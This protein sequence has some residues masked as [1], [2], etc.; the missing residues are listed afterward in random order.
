MQLNTQEVLSLYQEKGVD[1]QALIGSTLMSVE[2]T[3]SDYTFNFAHKDYSLA[4]IKKRVKYFQLNIKMNELDLVF[5]TFKI[6]GELFTIEKIDTETQQVEIQNYHSKQ[7]SVISVDAVRHHQYQEI[8]YQIKKF[9]SAYNEGSLTTK[10]ILSEINFLFS[11]IKKIYSFSTDLNFST[12]QLLVRTIVKIISESKIHIIEDQ[13][14]S[15][16][17][18]ILEHN[19]ITINECKTYLEDFISY[20]IP[21][22]NA[23][24]DRL[25]HLARKTNYKLETLKFSNQLI[26]LLEDYQKSTFPHPNLWFDLSDLTLLTR[27][28]LHTLKSNFATIPQ[29][30]SLV[31][32]VSTQI[33]SI[34]KVASIETD[35]LF[36]LIYNQINELKELAKPKT[37]FQALEK[38]ELI[39][40]NLQQKN[41]HHINNS[42]IVSI[43]ET[44]T[45]ADL[46][47]QIP[48]LQQGETYKLDA[49]DEYQDN[50]ELYKLLA[51]KRI[52][53]LQTLDIPNKETFF[54]LAYKN[55]KEFYIQIHRILRQKQLSAFMHNSDKLEKQSL[56]DKIMAKLKLEDLTKS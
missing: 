49:A 27:H 45:I 40:L 12:T 48:E 22:L 18:S 32:F 47:I 13:I 8:I 51:A 50:F 33:E 26:E 14:H 29:I 9:E 56:I 53:W 37:C 43:Y 3:D 52:E 23:I 11:S 39:L 55:P 6:N 17:Q 25:S 2:R 46:G 41:I 31:D 4:E 54:E 28:K 19:L 21:V 1:L 34:L 7:K 20:D 5:P 36:S 38:L 24:S 30:V 15:W 10:E 44:Q 35:L 16:D 42:L